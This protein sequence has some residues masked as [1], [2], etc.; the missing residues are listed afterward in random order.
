[1]RKVII[2]LMG[3]LLLSLYGFQPHVSAAS[4]IIS[5][6]ATVVPQDKKV[7]NVIVYGKDVKLDGH[8][9]TAVIV[10]DGS[11]TIKEHAK[12]DGY[13]L[14]LGGDIYQEQ[15]A[16]V[17][18]EIFHLNF[19]DRSLNSLLLGGLTVAG[20]SLFKLVLSLFILLLT[21][22]IAY[23]GEQKVFEVSETFRERFGRVFLT[24]TVVTILLVF[25]FGLLILS[26]FGI[27][28]VLLVLIPCLIFWLVMISAF[29]QMLGFQL[30]ATGGSPPWFMLLFGLFIIMSVLNFPLLGI[31]LLLL[32]VFVSNGYMFEWIMNWFT[33]KRQN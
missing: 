23:L 31:I 27:P 19:N 26:I 2:I 6:K 4:T 5:H 16:D 1:M 21:F 32:S 25:L 24:G 12:L 14:V 3:A 29:G 22:L 10:V 17:P 7:D 20:I 9:Q 30:S 33:K 15:G 8:V 28:I 11:L 18:D 13:V